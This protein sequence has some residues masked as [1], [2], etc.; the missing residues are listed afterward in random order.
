MRALGTRRKRKTDDDFAKNMDGGSRPTRSRLDAAAETFVP[1]ADEGEGTVGET[2]Q[3]ADDNASGDLGPAAEDETS[4]ALEL[5]AD[6]DTTDATMQQTVDNASPTSSLASS[7]SLEG[8]DPFD[9]SF[10]DGN[11]DGPPP[12]DIRFATSYDLDEN[13]GRYILCVPPPPVSSPE[14]SPDTSPVRV[15]GRARPIFKPLA[16]PLDHWMLKKPS[17]SSARPQSTASPSTPT[18]LQNICSAVSRRLWAGNPAPRD[19]AKEERV[20]AEMETDYPQPPAGFRSSRLPHPLVDEAEFMRQL[21]ENRKGVPRDAPDRVPPQNS[22][23]ADVLQPAEPG[24]KNEW[25]YDETRESCRIAADARALDLNNASKTEFHPLATFHSFLKLPRELREK[26]YAHALR[27]PRPI[28]PQLC[29]PDYTSRPHPPS[30][31]ITLPTTPT[32][33]PKFHDANQTEHNAVNALLGITRVSK[34]VRDEAFAVF[35]STNTFVIGQDTSS[36]FDRLEYLGRFCMLR[37]VQFVILHRLEKRAPETLRGLSSYLK[38]KA[39]YEDDLRL[40]EHKKNL[41][42][43]VPFWDGKGKGKGKAV[44]VPVPVKE[45]VKKSTAALVGAS[46]ASLTN[47]PQYLVGGLADLNVLICLGK[48]CTASEE[49]KFGENDNS[50]GKAKAQDD[51][52]AN[53]STLTLPIPS[54]AVFTAYPTLSWFPLVAAG[55]GI[56]LHWVEGVPVD[57]SGPGWMQITWRQRWGKKDTITPSTSNGNGNGDKSSDNSGSGIGAQTGGKEWES[58]LALSANE[59]AHRALQL[60]P[61][62]EEEK[63]ERKN[64][65]YRIGCKGQLKWFDVLTEKNIGGEVSRV[66]EGGED[67]A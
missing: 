47:H 15:A 48:L 45:V 58:G 28:L 1:A 25:V 14:C 16:R 27:T 13:E 26:I 56:K 8:E 49:T 40:E 12:R 33:T 39:K 55:L 43:K 2:N 9:S 54:A 18:T 21:Q 61:Q 11:N 31:L 36:Y 63:R 64:L 53:P 52:T 38:H 29:D 5:S 59:V 10:D 3:Q 23:R 7:P 17:G 6:D 51:V 37:N 60:N 19:L 65:Y 20:R 35:Y 57:D 62:L 22:P 44:P 42:L 34:Q 66:G 67:S 41:V 46:Y 32:T 30:R 50:K 4:E 24:L